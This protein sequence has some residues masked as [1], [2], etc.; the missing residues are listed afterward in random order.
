MTPS[1]PNTV[2]RIVVECLRGSMG[3]FAWDTVWGGM[4][5]ALWKPVDKTVWGAL[6]AAVQQ[7]VNMTIHDA[8][9]MNVS[10]T[11]EHPN[12]HQ[13]VVELRQT[14]RGAT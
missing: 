14:H 2:R 4:Y 11:P 1:D 13:F 12:L 3:Q 9:G 10:N 6:D 5:W 8:V 7:G